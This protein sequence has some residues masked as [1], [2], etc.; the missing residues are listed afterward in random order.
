MYVFG[1]FLPLNK[2]PL[3]TR[4]TESV[5]GVSINMKTAY[6]SGNATKQRCLLPVESRV[7]YVLYISNRKL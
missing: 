2:T 4:D 6:L 3:V 1:R 7:S 5:G